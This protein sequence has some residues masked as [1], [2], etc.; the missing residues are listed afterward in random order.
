MDILKPI[1]SKQNLI[2]HSA[3]VS[4]IALIAALI[5][6]N[7]FDQKFSRM[8][9]NDLPSSFKDLANLITDIGLGAPY[10]ILM[11][12][13]FLVLQFLTPRMRRFDHMTPRLRLMKN[14]AI[15]TMSAMLVSGI[16]VHLIKNSVGR[17]RPYGSPDFYPFHFEPFSFTAKFQSFPSGHTQVLF[18]VATM[19]TAIRPRLGKFVFPL[20]G[21]FALTRVLV[22]DHFLSDVIFGSSVGYVGALLSLYLLKKKYPFHHE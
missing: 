8:I 17:M 18:C 9:Q 12:S 19:I 16:Y 7:L 20:A 4:G 11:L 1:S 21:L 3:L 10:F 14:V 15:Q 5:S 6:M 13:L 2:R 22:F